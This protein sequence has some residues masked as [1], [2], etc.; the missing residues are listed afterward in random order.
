M[1]REAGLDLEGSAEVNG[2]GCGAGGGLRGRVRQANKGENC[3]D[4]DRLFGPVGEFGLRDFVVEGE[5]FARGVR[6]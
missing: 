5:G 6:I 3:G 2:R 4:A 1:H